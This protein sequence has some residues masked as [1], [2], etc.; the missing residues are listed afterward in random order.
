MSLTRTNTRRIFLLLNRRGSLTRREI[1]K[2]L[3]LQR[4]EVAARVAELI[5]AGKVT[6]SGSALSPI[7]KRPVECVR[8]RA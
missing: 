2:R 3:R 1:A 6:V 7:T 5:H 4:G 8:V